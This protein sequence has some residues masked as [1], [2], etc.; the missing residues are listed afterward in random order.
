[1][2][3]ALPL[4]GGIVSG[5]GGEPGDFG[6][7]SW[8]GGGGAGDLGSAHPPCPISM[9]SHFIIDNMRILCYIIRLISGSGG[10]SDIY[11]YEFGNF[12]TVIIR[13]RALRGL[14]EFS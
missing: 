8:A 12:V 13:I 2:N 9:P 4:M 1:M 5:A 14:P 10:S 6:G 7:Q 3:R 11:T